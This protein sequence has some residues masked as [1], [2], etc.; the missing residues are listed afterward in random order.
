[1]YGVD[2]KKYANKRGNRLLAKFCE[3]FIKPFERP[4]K[5]SERLTKPFERIEKFSERFPKPFERI[6][7]FS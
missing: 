2:I 7:T 3:R 5:F 6:E 1:M 4:E